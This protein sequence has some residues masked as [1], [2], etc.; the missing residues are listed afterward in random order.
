MKI[1][2]ICA[3]KDTTDIIE[4]VTYRMVKYFANHVSDINLICRIYGKNL[5]LN[6]AEQTTWFKNGQRTWIDVSP[7]KRC[8]WTNKHMKWFTKIIN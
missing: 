8:K 1:K 7:K 3:R 4:K 6:S 2:K 5:E